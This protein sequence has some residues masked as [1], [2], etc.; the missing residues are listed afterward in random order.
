ML[1][2]ARSGFLGEP[3]DLEKLLGEGSWIIFTSNIEEVF[4]LVM[5][6]NSATNEH[7]HEVMKTHE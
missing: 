5:K 6:G 3:K 2:A 4:H 1:E 7:I